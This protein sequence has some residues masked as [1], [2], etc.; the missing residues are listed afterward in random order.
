MSRNKLAKRLLVCKD[1]PHMPTSHKSHAVFVNCNTTKL[2]MGF[3][4]PLESSDFFAQ[5]V[6]KG[7]S[8]NPSTLHLTP[9]IIIRCTAIVIRCTK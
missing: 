3:E 7:T 8:V 4:I 6:I 5:H 1:V 9:V 2:L